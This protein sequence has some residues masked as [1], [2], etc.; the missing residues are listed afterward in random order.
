MAV[1]PIGAMMFSRP[2][3]CA[4]VACVA[5]SVTATS[6]AQ[7]YTYNVGQ[8]V[9]PVFEGWER[10]SDGTLTMVFGYFNRN[11]VEEPIVPI[12][13]NNRFEPGEPDRGQPGHFYPRR[14]QFIFSVNVPK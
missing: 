12:G 1:M 7:Q 4:V 14:Q 8:N 5:L 9:V 3:L 6:G 2:T 10:N 13:P 11:L